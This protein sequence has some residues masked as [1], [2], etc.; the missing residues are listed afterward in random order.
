VSPQ[1]TAA[2]RAEAARRQPTA[3]V[4]G[5]WHSH[6]Q[7]SEY[8]GTD[9]STQR[10]WTQ[11]DSVGLLVFATGSPWAHAYLGPLA[12]RATLQPAAPQGE[13]ERVPLAREAPAGPG[14]PAVPEPPGRRLVPRR[15]AIAAAIIVIVLVI[16]LAWWLRGLVN[17]V[18]S[19]TGQLSQ[20]RQA[21]AG[22]AG[23]PSPPPA[24]SWSCVQRA[25][26]DYQCSVPVPSTATQVQWRL[27]GEPCG[28][29]PSV[30][31]H[32]PQG[33]ATSVIE[34]QLRVATVVYDLGAQE[35]TG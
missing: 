35:L 24:V 10:M 20:I 1:A 34:L 29:Q 7:P 6:G 14:W 27:N 18:N 33:A 9:R 12:R 21:I 28:N 8:S 16:A 19:E 30:L 22:T 17:A 15:G 31:V 11:P 3:D 4:V 5:W 2:L 26:R 23:S 25:G 13:R 32:L